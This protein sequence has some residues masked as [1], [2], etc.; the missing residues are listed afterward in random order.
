MLTTDCMMHK[1]I[2]ILTKC[3]V[4]SDMYARVTHTRFRNKSTHTCTSTSTRDEEMEKSSDE[5]CI[6]PASPNSPGVI[7]DV[8]LTAT[9]AR[10]LVMSGD[11]ELGAVVLDTNQTWDD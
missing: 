11:V 10:Q 9:V 8:D 4:Q 6:S 7:S 2:I 5:D 1:M 3:T